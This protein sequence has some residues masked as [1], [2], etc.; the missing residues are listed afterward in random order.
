MASTVVRAQLHAAFPCGWNL[1]MEGCS[2]GQTG[3]LE[4]N[5]RGSSRL[6]RQLSFVRAAGEEGDM[7]RCASLQGW[8]QCVTAVKKFPAHLGFIQQQ[9]NTGLKQQ[10]GSDL[11]VS[12]IP[13]LLIF[14]DVTEN[15][16]VLDL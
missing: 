11:K 3:T 7:R 12:T 16:M 2:N 15:V 5:G 6:L 4:W 14:R 1:K 10:V 9:R 8:P 13:G